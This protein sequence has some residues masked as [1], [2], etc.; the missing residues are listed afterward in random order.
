M[1][2]A[3]SE[4]PTPSWVLQPN[5]PPPVFLDDQPTTLKGPPGSAPGTDLSGTISIAL[6]S[7]LDLA[8]S[9]LIQLYG[10]ASSRAI[11]L[12]HSLAEADEE[13]RYP[14]PS[15]NASASIHSEASAQSLKAE[16]IHPTAASL[17]AQHNPPAHK[18]STSSMMSTASSSSSTKAPANG[19]QDADIVY[20]SAHEVWHHSSSVDKHR[21]LQGPGAHDF[22]FLFKIP[23]SLPATDPIN[24]VRYVLRCIV[25]AKDGKILAALVEEVRV[26]RL[27]RG[28]DENTELPVYDG[29]VTEEDKSIFVGDDADLPP[30]PLYTEGWK[31]KDR[32]L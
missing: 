9:I 32:M 21:G 4:M 3:S 19:A 23:G 2:Q 29:A 10:A 17:K 20:C 31:G 28:T 30:P 18:N 6:S 7:D 22:R 12:Q 13:D 27:L 25:Q 11:N 14:A 16:Y 24:G 26:R 1:L 5:K 8:D 15:Y